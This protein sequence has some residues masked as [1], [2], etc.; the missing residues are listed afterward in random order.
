MNDQRSHPLATTAA[1]KQ[2]VR[3]DM[4]IM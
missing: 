2:T 3:S 1:T 4:L